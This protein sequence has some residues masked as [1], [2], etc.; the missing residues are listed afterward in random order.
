[1]IDLYSGT[2]GSGKSL[3]VAEKIYYALRLG[4]SVICNF[5]IDV[6]RIK[7][8]RIDFSYIPNDMLTPD[9]LIE[10]SRQHFAGR[11]V[12]EDEILL[13]IDECQLLFNA[14]AACVL[15]R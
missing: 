10:Y 3:H 15:L 11:R 2:P 13:V 8:K 7:R 4:R 6:S 5:D 12:V 9:R 14:R 1:M